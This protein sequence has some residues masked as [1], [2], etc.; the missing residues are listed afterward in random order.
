MRVAS[1]GRMDKF[2]SLH[3]T[4]KVPMKTH[5][6]IAAAV[7][8]IT[9]LSSHAD[10]TTTALDLSAGNASFG[11]NNA[12]GI[13]TDTYTFTLLGSLFHLTGTASSS[14]SGTQDLNFTSLTINDSSNNVVATFAGNLGTPSNEFYS[15][16]EI[17]LGAGLYSLVVKGTNTPTQASYSGNIAISPVPEPGTLAMMLAGAAAMGFV[18]LRRQAR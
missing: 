10:T 13:F 2:V 16:P 17:T 15:L 8:A 6:L 9:S 11:R 5:T 7:L 3:P 12:I 18:S 14:Q 4:P 1:P